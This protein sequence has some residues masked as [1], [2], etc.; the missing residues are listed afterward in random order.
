M[1]SDEA[2]KV[3]HLQPFGDRL[4]DGVKYALLRLLFTDFL[5]HVHR[6]HCV[7]NCRTYYFKTRPPLQ[8]SSFWGL[9]DT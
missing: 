5:L 9:V 4:G 6:S 2:G 3:S 7:T 1:M 8:G